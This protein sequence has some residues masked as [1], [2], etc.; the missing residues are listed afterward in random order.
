MKYFII[1]PHKQ[2]IAPKDYQHDPH[3][4]FKKFVDLEMGM[5]VNDQEHKAQ[6]PEYLSYA[7]KLG[8]EWEPNADAGFIQYNYRAAL[9]VRLVKEY[10]RQLVHNIGLPVYEVHGSN[11]FD[12]SHPVVDAYAKLYGDRL[13][14]FES[15]KKDVV[16]SYDA[17]YPQFNLAAKA[18]LSHKQLPFAHFSISDCYRHEQSGECMLL[19][20][21]RRFYMPDL[22]PYFKNV[23]EAFDWYPAIEKQLLQAAAD[24][25]RHYHIV[26]EVSSVAYWE[27]Y[28]AQ[29]SEVAARIGHDI[30]IAIHEGDQN[31]YWIINVDYKII[32][33]LHQAREICCIQIDVNNAERL[34]IKYINKDSQNKHP[35]I[36]H[37]AVPG[38]IERFIYMMLDNFKESF[39][40]WLHPS[41]IRLLPIN[42]QHRVFCESI[43]EKYKQH[44]RIEID[45]RSESISKKIKQAHEDLIPFPIVIGD[46]EVANWESQEELLSAMEAIAASS[47]GKPFI[48]LSY[49]RSLSLQIK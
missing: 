32:D 12:L 39:P 22:H 44:A 31:K 26:V 14:Q 8:F 33:Q 3:S 6:K 7:H 45:D 42:D 20:R 43:A 48:P 10:A 28:Q 23:D 46:R 40:L 4:A 15:G 1:N 2:V 35:V 21:Q 9:I 41:Q 17:S 37:A 38:G 30:L 5:Q 25:K 36:I 18:L 47:A 16:M 49:P 19:Y 27:Q 29:I 13:F 11:M 24:I 34:N